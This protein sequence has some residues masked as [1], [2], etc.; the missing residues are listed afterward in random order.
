MS[1]FPAL[2]A[3]SDV[4]TGHGCYPPTGY[5]P[6]P[7]GASPNVIINGLNAHR[8][9]DTTIPH[10][11]IG[12]DIHSDVI[13]TGDPTVLV[14][15]RPIAI[16]GLSILAPSGVVSGYSSVNVMVKCGSLNNATVVG[17]FFA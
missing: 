5:L 12:V 4:T 13:A 10:T 11:C 7:I 15:G 9:G 14:N 8:V 16:L 2:Y 3:P 1:L 17:Q 6:P